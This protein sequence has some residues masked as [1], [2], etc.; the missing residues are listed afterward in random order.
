MGAETKTK[1]AIASL[2]AL[3]ISSIDGQWEFVFASL[4]AGTWLA[5]A[6]QRTLVDLWLFKSYIELELQLGNIDRVRTIYEKQLE[7][8]PAR[9]PKSCPKHRAKHRAFVRELPRRSA[10][11]PTQRP[12]DAPHKKEPWPAPPRSLCCST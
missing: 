4:L 11:P 7:T 10:Q 3:A 9:L 1:L 6:V 5:C 8:F 2:S 12:R